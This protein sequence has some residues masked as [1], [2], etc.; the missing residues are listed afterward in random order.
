MAQKI[1]TNE[2]LE[3]FADLYKNPSKDILENADAI[4]ILTGNRPP[5]Q[6]ENISRIKYAKTLLKKFRKNMRVIFSGVTEEKEDVI[7]LMIKNGIPKET[8]YFQDCGKRGVANTKTQFE[9]LIIDP[10][11]KNLRNLVFVTSYYHIPRVRRVAEKF[12]HP[13]TKFAVV[14]DI[15]DWK[16]YNSFLFVID[17]IK[18]II[19]YS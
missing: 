8:C 1:S 17:E 16:M 13:K 7:N 15:D 19:E 11:T 12:L 4:I 10:L 9:T 6:W 14:G 3:E 2:L 18:K 5:I